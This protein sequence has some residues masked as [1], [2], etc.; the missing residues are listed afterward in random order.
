[1]RTHRGKTGISSFLR[2]PVSIAVALAFA[3]GAS[4]AVYTVTNANEIGAG[5]FYQ[6]VSDANAACTAGTDAAPVIQFSGPFVISP[7]TT[8][9]VFF[10]GG[11]S[12]Y[13]PTIDGW[14]TPTATQN[15]AATGFNATLPVVFNMSGYPYGGCVLQFGDNGHG[16][17]LT[18]KGIDVRDFTYGGAAACGQK[19]NLQ[20]NRFTNVVTGVDVV[21]AANIG[22]PALADRNVIA[23]NTNAAIQLDSTGTFNIVNNLLGTVDGVT[24]APNYYGI[25]P[26]SSCCESQSGS[27]TNN[28]IV[29]NG[30]YAVLVIGDLFTISGNKINT[31]VSGTN[32]LGSSG[33]GISLNYSY[34]STISGNVIAGSGTAIYNANSAPSC[35]GGAGNVSITGNIIGNTTGNS[36]LGNSV[37]IFDSYSYGTR[38]DS[39]VISGNAG[40]GIQISGGNSTTITSNLV[41]T[42]AGGNTAMP[43]D[44]GIVLT[45]GTTN[46]V[47]DGNT[48]S[49]NFIGVSIDQSSMNTV[50]GNRIGLNASG[51]AALGNDYGLQAD[52]STNLTID[53]NGIS[54]NMYGGMQ[55]G[56]VQASLFTGNNIGGIA[57]NGSDGV[58]LLPITCSSPAA[59]LAAKKGGS[60]AISMGAVNQPDGNT[61]S[62]NVIARNTGRGLWMVGGNANTFFQNNIS[63]NTMD[64]LRIDPDCCDVYGGVISAAV[65]NAF[66]E[67]LIYGNG[68]KNVNLGFD[69]GILPNDSLDTDSGKPNNWQNWPVLNSAVHDPINNNTTIGFTL[70]SKAGQY[71][72]DFFA[73]PSPNKVPEGQYYLGNTF[74]TIAADGPT[75]G[76]YAVNGTSW[77]N[78]S[79]IAIR[80]GPEVPAVQDSSELA[81]E[82]SASTLP[83]P[84]VNIVPTSIDFGDVVVGRSSSSSTIT[85]TSTGTADY[86]ISALRDTT[87]AGPAICSTGAFVCSTTCVEGTP[88]RPGMSCTVGASFAP[89]ATGPQS[90][91]LAVCDNTAGSPRTLTLTG[92]GVPP[93][94]VNIAY[95]PS[96]ASFGEILVGTQS[97]SHSFTL[98]NAGATQVYLSA[99]STTGD[100]NIVGGTCGATLAAGASCDT[101]VA[102]APTTKGAQNGL[103]QITGSNAP[104]AKAALH[105]KVATASTTVAVANLQGSGAQFGD[106]RLPAS[107]SFG[108]LV[109][110]GAPGSLLLPLSN[111]GNGPLTISSISVAG[112]FTMTNDCG[113]SLAVGASCTVVTNFNPSTLGTFNGTLTIVSD[114]PGGSRAIALTATVI[115]DARP[116]VRVDPTTVGFGARLIGSASPASHV[117]VTNEGAQTAVL[118]LMTFVQP[119]TGGNDFSISSTNCPASL[120]PQA[121]CS[122]DL[123]MKAQGF[124]PRSGQFIVPSNSADSPRTVNLS[125]TGCRPFA[126]GSNR[127]PRDPCA[128]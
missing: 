123:V 116:V 13:N 42:D 95:T 58:Q 60:K 114:A 118:G 21:D 25:V 46:S 72:I 43:N 67:N 113:T 50:R 20:G 93:P 55:L 96:F 30:G 28:V 87:C 53:S 111:T 26:T 117:T 78:I 62:G 7:S 110:H 92:N 14:S 47:I 41:G 98:T 104:L 121:S 89:T 4:A 9:P 48:I 112:P 94:T 75:S 101:D 10:C 40:T 69:G 115:A 128:P 88:Y 33:Y 85:A 18:V 31:D 70:D 45:N 106:L 73:N 100:F 16:G 2:T 91:S 74:L 68:A 1:M 125:G 119:E 122:V 5:S 6:A 82:V 52:C 15:T 105:A 124:G 23:G 11:T 35:C 49:G 97:P 99:A 29:T 120:A 80:V 90:K 36:E 76:S 19:L 17:S 56:A 108:A 79:A 84:A 39:N 27:I 109:L 34:G 65:G 12:A 3:Q 8:L 107:L 64:G 77:D 59:A 66:V 102:F 61:F 54:G 38:I 37:G 103:L 81:A 71:R 86:V 83:V 63:A 126:V 24:A 57:P 127:A 22:G 32:L 51:T 44:I